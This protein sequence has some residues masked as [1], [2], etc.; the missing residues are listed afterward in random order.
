MCVVKK[1]E[2]DKD[3]DN[4]LCHRGWNVVKQDL[5]GKVEWPKLKLNVGMG[6]S[7]KN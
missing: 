1:K 6:I 2:R 7:K 3:K 5:S 4:E